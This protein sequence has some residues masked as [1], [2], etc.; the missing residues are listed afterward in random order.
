MPRDQVLI[1]K[2]MAMIKTLE[3]ETKFDEVRR[4]RELL[5]QRLSILEPAQLGKASYE[6]G[7]SW[8]EI[9]L[10]FDNFYRYPMP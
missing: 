3:E 6:G 8:Y 7:Y 4:C 10:T 1:E 9:G 2:T 5:H